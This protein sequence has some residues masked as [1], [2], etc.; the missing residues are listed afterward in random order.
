L[1]F[2]VA[3]LWCCDCPC[4]HIY[5]F[6]YDEIALQRDSGWMCIYKYSVYSSRAK[7]LEDGQLIG[8]C[9]AEHS[10]STELYRVLLFNCL[11]IEF[12]GRDT[13]KTYYISDSR[14]Q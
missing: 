4:E 7:G 3:W 6:A 9:D 14:G 13:A 10:T 5:G 11:M 12:R 1:C 8:T 2:L